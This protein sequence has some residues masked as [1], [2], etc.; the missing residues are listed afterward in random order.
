MVEL[1]FYQCISNFIMITEN[2]SS[3]INHIFI[4]TKNISNILSFT[5]CSGMTDDYVELIIKNTRNKVGK[6]F[7]FNKVNWNTLLTK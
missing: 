2:S 1:G 4:R 5:Y 7:N 6:V 3:C